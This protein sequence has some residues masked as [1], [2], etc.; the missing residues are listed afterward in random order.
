MTLVNCTCNASAQTKR[1]N[2]VQMTTSG[3][4][5]NS[6]S[7]LGLGEEFMGICV[8]SDEMNFFVE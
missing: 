8:K 6:V 3:I 5:L 1:D 4:L 2:H 7:E